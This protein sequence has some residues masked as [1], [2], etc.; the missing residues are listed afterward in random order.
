MI[1][2]MISSLSRIV[3]RQ[4]ISFGKRQPHSLKSP[5]HSR[6]RI[7]QVVLLG[8]AGHQRFHGPIADFFGRSVRSDEEEKPFIFVEF[9]QRRFS[10]S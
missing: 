9:D 7:V 10:R 2:T 3:I 8:E 5:D 4:F 1:D 6:G